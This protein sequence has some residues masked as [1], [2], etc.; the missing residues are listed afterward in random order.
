MSLPQ[1]C[2]LLKICIKR[3]DV[4]GVMKVELKLPV[5]PRM[6]DTPSLFPL[7]V[8]IWKGRRNYTHLR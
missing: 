5:M 8:N 3:G 1:D 6:T 4:G 7:N 2:L